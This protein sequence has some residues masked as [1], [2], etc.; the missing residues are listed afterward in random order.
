[1]TINAINH[2][3]HFLDDDGVIIFFVTEA[4]RIRK[5]SRNREKN[6][7]LSLVFNTEQ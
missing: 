1:M 7:E 2:Y 5:L 3:L 4:T 6:I